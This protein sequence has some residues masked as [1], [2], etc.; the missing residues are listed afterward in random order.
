MNEIPLTGVS[1]PASAESVF[2]KVVSL[3]WYDGTTSGAAMCSLAALAFRF[4]I[5]A[6]GPFQETRVFAFS[7]LSLEDFEE[8]IRLFSNLEAPKWPCWFPRWPTGTPGEEA[9]RTALDARLANAK[10][11]EFVVACDSMFK[12][13]LAAERL[14]A[15]SR[16]LIPLEFDGY[17]AAD[18]FEYW[19]EF[20]EFEDPAK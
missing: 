11:P 9:L 5:L 12:T 7:P 18:N 10:F 14:D 4:D 16:Q 2:D 1:F 3:G 6:W 15:P 17:P 20:L 8:I 19:R 13:L